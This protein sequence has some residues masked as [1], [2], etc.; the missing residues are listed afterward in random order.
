[1]APFTVVNLISGA[2]HIR[3]GD[4]MLGTLVGM[5]PG[6]A[7][8]TALG[9]RLRQVL[10]NPSAANVGLLVLFVG[11]WIALSVALQVT[12]SRRRKRNAG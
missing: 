3:F 6:I 4:Y 12:L 1:L 11:V 10:H 2:S 7:V 8:M 9:D 5:A